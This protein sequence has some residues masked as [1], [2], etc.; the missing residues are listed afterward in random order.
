MNNKQKDTDLREAL[1][2]KYADTPKLPADFMSSME[3]RMEKRGNRPKVVWAI[4]AIAASILLVVM[5]VKPDQS[6]T[7]S[8]S[9][10]TTHVARTPRPTYI[11][12]LDLRT[13]EPST[14]VP[15]KS[16]PVAKRVRTRQ[17]P[18][19]PP[20][21]PEVTNLHY[22]AYTPKE[23]S[24]YQAPSRVDEFIANLAKFSKVEAVKLECTSDGNDTTEVSTAYIFEDKE[25]LD[26]FARLL[27]VACWYDTKTPGYL[28]NFSRQQFLF[29][30]KD[31]RK[32]EKYLWL[33]ERISD[34]RI[35]LYCT[36]SPIQTT[37]SSTCYQQYRE[38]LMHTNFNLMQIQ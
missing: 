13:S 19:P 28:L 26:L 4:L 15:Q 6:A 23:D 36:H 18:T 1:N 11:D 32:Q 25:E 9:L 21:S 38:Q 8:R 10:A 35:L 16:A 2:R 3:Q 30:L 29:T 31:L 17:A 20:S 37:V 24:A 33:A 34:R 14:H 22:A 27:Q 12:T 5:L 7:E